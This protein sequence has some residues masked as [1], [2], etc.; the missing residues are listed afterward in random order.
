MLNVFKIHDFLAKELDV[1]A[2]LTEAQ[3]LNKDKSQNGTVD[4]ATDL[5]AV[6]FHQQIEIT[7]VPAVTEC[8]QGGQITGNQ[9]VR[10]GGPGQGDEVGVDFFGFLFQTNGLQGDG[11][12][13]EGG[14]VDDF[15]PGCGIAA[16][17]IHQ[18]FRVLQHPG[19]RADPVG[20]AGLPQIGTGGTVQEHGS[21]GDFCVKLFFGE[22]SF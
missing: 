19:F 11:L 21:C 1:Y 17:Q 6:V 15:R 12:G 2:R 13:L 8:G 9:T 18:D 4:E 20:H 7:F 5:A 22:H 3:L 10:G 16:L 14:G